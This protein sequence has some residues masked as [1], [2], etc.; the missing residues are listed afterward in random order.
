MNGPNKSSKSALRT[1]TVVL[2]DPAIPRARKFMLTT[3]AQVTATT[4]ETSRITVFIGPVETSVADTNAHRHGIVCVKP[5]AGQTQATA[6]S[7][8]KIMKELKLLGLEPVTYLQPCKDLRACVEYAFKANVSLVPEELA[9]QINLNKHSVRNKEFLE[10][11]AQKIIEG[12]DEKPTFNEFKQKLISSNFTFPEQLIK[13]AY[14]HMTFKKENRFEKTFERIKRSTALPPMPPTLGSKL[15]FKITKKFGNIKWGEA[16]LDHFDLQIALLCLAIEA[17]DHTKKEIE[18]SPHICLTGSAGKGKTLLG[19]MLY[20]TS[21]ASLMTNDSQGV[22]QLQLGPKRKMFKMDDL[23]AAILRDHKIAASIKSMYHNDWSAKIHGS[24]ENNKAAAVFITT[25]E[26]DPLLKLSDISDLKAI[27]RRFVTANVSELE[28]APKIDRLYSVNRSV[29]D[30]IVIEILRTINSK[31]HTRDCHKD[32]QVAK[33]YVAAFA[34]AILLDEQ[35]LHQDGNPDVG[36]SHIEGSSV[37]HRGA[38]SGETS[39]THHTPIPAQPDSRNSP[40]FHAGRNGSCHRTKKRRRRTTTTQSGTTDVLPKKKART[41]SEETEGNN[42]ITIEFEELT[43]EDMDP[44]HSAV[45]GVLP[46]TEDNNRKFPLLMSALA[47]RHETANIQH[48]EGMDDQHIN[49]MASL[50]RDGNIPVQEPDILAT[51]IAS[52]IGEPTSDEEL[53]AFAAE[54]EL[55]DKFL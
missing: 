45:S 51:A 8:D 31:L 30:E 48:G 2:T 20:P 14:E 38:A 26:A 53:L 43:Q 13:R 24:K 23:P 40:P 9:V 50:P 10:A 29:S 41:S 35:R 36:A 22:G 11:Q 33:D 6:L 1:E 17:R 46:T 27:E 34:Q 7:K 28:K 42:G 15:F 52:T 44:N 54:I 5:L 19:K 39:G 18:I 55:G 32:L 25:N 47:L 4:L 21:I 16:N 49:E 12:F 37:P 3:A